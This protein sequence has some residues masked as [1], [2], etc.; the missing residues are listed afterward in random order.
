[1]KKSI[2]AAVLLLL[3]LIACACPAEEAENETALYYG[4]IGKKMDV[5]R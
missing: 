1:M 2:C 3:L 4:Y 5:H